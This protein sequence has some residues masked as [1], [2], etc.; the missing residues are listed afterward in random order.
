MHSGERRLQS[1]GIQ[2]ENEGEQVGRGG[3]RERHSD[4]N[5]ERGRERDKN[6]IQFNGF[7]KGRKIPYRVNNI[8]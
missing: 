7:K 3:G 1:K 2:T 8:R 4:R 6:D 5:Q